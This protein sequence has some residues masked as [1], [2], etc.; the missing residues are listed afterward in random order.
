MRKAMAFR[1]AYLKFHSHL[2][3]LK[4]DQGLE[5]SASVFHADEEDSRMKI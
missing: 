3:G 1:K 4:E 5:R 2:M